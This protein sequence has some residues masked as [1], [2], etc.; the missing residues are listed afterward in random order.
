M[1]TV[2]TLCFFRKFVELNWGTLV[3]ATL[4]GTIIGFFSKQ[5]DRFFEFKPFFKT[6]AAYFELS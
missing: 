3:M 1:S 2:M 5:L 6:F 4:N